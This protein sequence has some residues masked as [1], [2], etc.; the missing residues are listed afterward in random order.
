ML[1]SVAVW[2]I[3]PTNPTALGLLAGIAETIPC[4]GPFLSA[5]PALLTALP[6]GFAPALWRIAAYVGIHFF[7]G[8]VSA[9]PNERYFVTIPPALVLMGIVAVYLLF[10]TIG[11]ILA[12]PITVAL[13][14]LV[15]MDYVADPLDEHMQQTLGGS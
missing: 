10:G 13:Y 5:I 7:E 1:C 12:A 14:M 3:G 9:P 8:Y 6:Q 15:K 2:L 4:L 11:I